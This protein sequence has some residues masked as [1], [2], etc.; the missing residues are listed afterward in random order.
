MYGIDQGLLIV[1]PELPHSTS[2]FFITYPASSF[3]D[4]D[5]VDSD[6]DAWLISTNDDHSNDKSQQDLYATDDPEEMSEM[7]MGEDL[8]EMDDQLSEIDELSELELEISDGDELLD[9]D[10]GDSD[11]YPTK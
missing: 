1:D 3:V 2:F 10:E 6:D 9:L 4:T 7:E 5:D 8:S 11:E